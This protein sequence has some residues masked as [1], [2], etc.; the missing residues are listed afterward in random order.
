VGKLL[1][2]R[3]FFT[4]RERERERERESN[5]KKKEKNKEIDREHKAWFE[6][7]NK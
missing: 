1:R 6:K 3:S 5:K 2:K 4:Q 7:N